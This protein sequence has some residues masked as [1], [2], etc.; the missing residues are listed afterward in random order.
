MQFFLQKNKSSFSV[1]AMT[2]WFCN[3]FTLRG[4]GEGYIETL[5]QF[6][7]FSENLKLNESLKVFFFFFF[8][9]SH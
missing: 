4:T 8:K 2:L 7:H 1:L 5:Y 3:L 9:E 6:N